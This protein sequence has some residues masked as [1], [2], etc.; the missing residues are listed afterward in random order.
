MLLYFLQL[1]MLESQELYKKLTAFVI[2]KEKSLFSVISSLP[3][4]ILYFDLQTRY[5]LSIVLHSINTEKTL[6]CLQSQLSWLRFTVF[7]LLT[8]NMF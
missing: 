1:P 3:F 8:T 2:P 5:A 7:V 4:Q 6:I